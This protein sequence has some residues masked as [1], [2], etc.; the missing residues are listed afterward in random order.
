MIAFSKYIL[1]AIFFISIQAVFFKGIKP[2]LVLILVFFYSLKNGSKKGM[3]YGAVTGVMID[4]ASG[5]IFGPN[6]ISKMFI[7]YAVASIRQ[8]LFQW[9]FFA[10]TLMAAIF[11]LFDI[12]MIHICYEIF[13]GISFMSRPMNIPLLQVLYTTGFSLLAYP[14]LN[15]E[16][17]TRSLI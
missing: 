4:S 7:G 8:G 9:N 5:V 3:V 14:F 16:E 1:A 12:L 6:I 11:S 15:S 2:D 17:E 10:S 13:A